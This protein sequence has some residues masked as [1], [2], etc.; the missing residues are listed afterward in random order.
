MLAHDENARS[1]GSRA[2]GTDVS[3]IK[4]QHKNYSSGGSS[5]STKARGRG[6]AFLFKEDREAS[7]AVGALKEG[8]GVGR[9][10]GAFVGS[11]QNCDGT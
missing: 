3:A 10:R 5:S 7:V 6:V 2:P 11:K 8:R 9:G 1:P 4:I